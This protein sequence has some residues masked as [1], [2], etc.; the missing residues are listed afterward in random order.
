[1]PF[2]ARYQIQNATLAVQAAGNMHSRLQGIPHASPEY[3]ERIR[4]GLESVKWHGRL[5]KLQDNPAVYV[6]GAINVNSARDFLNSIK[7]RL[8]HPIITVMGVPK[9]RDVEGVY[10]IY[11][12][13]SDSLIITENNIHPYI[14]FPEK[15]DSLAIAQ[16]FHD[17][18]SH[19]KILPD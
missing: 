18:I 19:R 2:Y 1:L 10:Q 11:A 8:T 16:Q 15:E 7:N 12:E 9:D 14:H 13:I 4:K 6:D 17:D 3:V 5:Q